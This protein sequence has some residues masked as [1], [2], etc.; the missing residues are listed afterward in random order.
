MSIGIIAFIPGVL[1]LLGISATYLNIP[2]FGLAVHMLWLLAFSAL[3]GCINYYLKQ[4]NKQITALVSEKTVVQNQL[5]VAFNK[6][7]GIESSVNK[8]TQKFKSYELDRW[9]QTAKQ[10][11]DSLKLVFDSSIDG[12]TGV[13]NRKFLD[14]R[15]A[16]ILKKGTKISVIMLDIDHFKKVN[17]TYGHQAGDE[18]LQN[19][20]QVIKN[21]LRPEDLL[22][23]YGG[24]E[25]VIVMQKP[26][27]KALVVAE[28]IRKAVES[29]SVN[30]TAGNI[31]ITT[32]LGVATQNDGDTPETIVDRADKAL[33]Q[34][35]HKGRNRVEKEGVDQ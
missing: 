11:E 15:L 22:A 31:N 25:F 13:G 4:L 10:A 1:L 29:T 12:L 3:F 32:S 14:V 18:V 9:S 35:K 23:R 6:L 33:Y 21:I 30:T 5:T 17:D 24:E 19:F 2:G 34:A 16:D 8:L 26:L 27:G 28:R 7:F 20:A